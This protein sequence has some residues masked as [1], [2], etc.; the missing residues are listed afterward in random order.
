[1]YSPNQSAYLAAENCQTDPGNKYINRSQIYEC[2]N[3]DATQFNFWEHINRDQTFILDSHRSF[4][5]SVHQ[6]E[7]LRTFFNL[8][9]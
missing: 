5:C 2:G 8:R 6:C 3:K 1:M 9:R 4:I 7:C